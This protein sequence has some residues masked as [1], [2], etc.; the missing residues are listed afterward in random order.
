MV[1]ARQAG[2][3]YTEQTLRNAYEVKVDIAEP[4]PQDPKEIKILGRIVTFTPEGVQYEPD[5][6][7]MEKAIH[8]LGMG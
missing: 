3:D 1:V 2:R 6:G 5:P 7:H 4:E 8:D